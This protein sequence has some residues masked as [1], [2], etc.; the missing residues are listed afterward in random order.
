MVT[1]TGTPY[2]NGSQ[3]LASL[4]TFIDPTHRAAQKDWWDRATSKGRGVA[5]AEAISE[6]RQDFMVL[7][8]KDVVL[9][10]KLPPKIIQVRREITI[11]LFCFAF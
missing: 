2:N 9:K 8:K 3:D 10:G 1:L 6:W 5:V 7:R 11:S 4:M